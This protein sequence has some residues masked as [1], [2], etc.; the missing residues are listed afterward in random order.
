LKYLLPY[1]LIG[2]ISFAI[3]FLI[4]K[5]LIPHLNIYLA[6]FIST[7]TASVFSFITNINLNYKRRDNK[8]NRYIKFILVINFGAF[9]SSVGIKL[10]L[11][12]FDPLVAKLITVPFAAG[13]QFILNTMWTFKKQA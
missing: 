5:L 10:L 7:Y 9:V 4:F 3:D 2:L 13:I 1:I 6:N 11:G 12:F 8:A